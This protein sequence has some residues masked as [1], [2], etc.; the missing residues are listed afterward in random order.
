MENLD[1]LGS[2]I[3]SLGVLLEGGD[4]QSESVG[5]RRE[6]EFEHVLVVAGSKITAAKIEAACD[7]V[8]K[9]LLPSEAHNAVASIK[10]NV[11]LGHLKNVVGHVGVVLLG[12][13]LDEFAVGEHSRDTTNAAHV[14]ELG[15]SL[16]HAATVWALE[17]LVDGVGT[18]DISLRGVRVEGLVED[19]SLDSDRNRCENRSLRVAVAV[20]K[21]GK[22]GV[23]NVDQSPLNHGLGLSRRHDRLGHN[24]LEETAKASRTSDVRGSLTDNHASLDPQKQLNVGG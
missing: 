16:V 11:L 8:V 5:G 6:T 12:G 9:D 20:P 23:V 21:T 4:V 10:W 24:V 19:R 1:G 22:L 13:A 14:A 18:L 2:L 3:E 15:Q 7:H 17:Q